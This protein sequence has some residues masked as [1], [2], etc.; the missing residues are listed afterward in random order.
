MKKLFTLFLAL[1]ASIGTLF[2]ESGTC[3]DNLTWDLTDGVLTISGEGEMTDWAYDAF[4]PWYSYRKEIANVTIGNGVTNIGDY[5]FYDC[6]YLLTNMTIPN[7]VTSIGKWAFS[8]C[9]S[10]TSVTIP[11]SVTS[12][13]WEAFSGCSGLT[14]IVIPNSVTNFGDYAFAGCT[15]LT[16]P[17]Y[18]AHLFAKMPTSYS[19]AYTIPDGI[20]SIA[21][22]A[23][24]NCTGLTSITIGNSVTSIGE[25]AFQDCVG[26]KSIIIPSNVTRIAPDA[27][28]GCSHLTSIVVLKGNSVYD[29]RNNCNAIIKTASNTLMIGCNST[30]IPNSVTCI[31][32]RA[33][34]DCTGLTSVTI[35]NSVTSIGKGAFLDC[36]GLKCINIPSNV[37]RI[38]P[39]AFRGCSHLTSIVVLKGNSVY[40]SRNNCNAI[41]KTASNTLMIG[42]NSTIIPNSVTC[43]G[44]GAFAR[45]ENLTSI[46]IP[47]S[48]DSIG[49]RVFS[50]C[51]GL[52]SI[53]CEAVTPPTCRGRVSDDLDKTIPLYVPVGSID[54]YKAAEQWKDFG[55]NIKP[56]QATP[57]DVTTI[58]AIPTDNSVEIKWPAI[59][60]A[61]TYTIKIWKG[62]ELICTIIFNEQGQLTIVFN[63][64]TRTN[65]TEQTQIAGF[66]F[67]VKGLESGTMYSYTVTAEDSSGN[68]INEEKGDFTTKMF[69]DVSIVQSEKMPSVKYIRNGQLFIQRG[70]EVF[71]AQG[72]RVR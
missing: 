33:F 58:V 42:C 5:A 68:V 49:L 52:T 59:T 35:P 25:G 14:S 24:Y 3:G 63:A 57:I 21:G 37:T 18:N 32:S 29:S 69:D 67:T 11:N 1:V 6:S 56:I 8:N 30:I 46:T 38:D 70:N 62:S 41:I 45:C 13:G 47:N 19:G 50:G 60:N 39:D 20:E 44:D 36:V 72:A 15:G 12:I 65:E 66:A 71:N 34:E 4:A 2:A 43:I 51:S 10:L 22:G 7:S 28:S 55:E 16:S 17:V 53:T 61:T 54:A 9:S 26:L 31:G 64:P 27:F 40:D 23:F 48:V